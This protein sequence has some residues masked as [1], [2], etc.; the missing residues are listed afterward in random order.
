M[1]MNKA[2]GTVKGTTTHQLS[3]QLRTATVPTHKI[4]NRTIAVTVSDD[5]YVSVLAGIDVGLHGGNNIASVVRA[6]IVKCIESAESVATEQQKKDYVAR[7][8][9]MLNKLHRLLSEDN[10]SVM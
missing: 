2:K 1:G 3:K 9:E 7:K 6:C 10:S 4:R 5:I 8:T